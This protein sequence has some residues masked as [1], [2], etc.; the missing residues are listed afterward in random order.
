MLQEMR[1]TE[2]IGRPFPGKDMRLS[3]LCL[4]NAREMLARIGIAA[5]AWAGNHATFAPMPPP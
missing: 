2:G 3:A 4:V 1:S 5:A